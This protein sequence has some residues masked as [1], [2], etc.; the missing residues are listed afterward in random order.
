MKTALLASSL[1]LAALLF[2]LGGSAYAAAP[3]FE[4]L[5][6]TGPT[7]LPP[8]QSETQRVT[9]EAKAAV[10]VSASKQEGTPAKGPSPHFGEEDPRKR[11]AHVSPRAHLRSWRTIHARRIR[12]PGVDLTASQAR[13]TNRPRTVR[14]CQLGTSNYLKLVE[15]SHRRHRFSGRVPIGD[16]LPAPSS[17]I[18]WHRGDCG[19]RRDADPLQSDHVR[20]NTVVLFASAMSPIPFD[21]SARANSRVPSSRFTAFGPGSVS[22]SGGRR[23]RLALHTSSLRRSARE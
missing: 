15:Q 10:S 20:P 18:A 13:L 21:A 11:H 2:A 5:A 6:I 14:R 23:H 9:V 3:G 1:A 16:E 22:V 7:H 19:W 17:H 8:K 4:L 12:L